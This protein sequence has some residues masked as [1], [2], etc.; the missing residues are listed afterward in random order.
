MITQTIQNNLRK[1]Q[2]NPLNI[3]L[4]LMGF[5]DKIT[6]FKKNTSIIVNDTNAVQYVIL[7]RKEPFGHRIW[8]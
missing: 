4:N 1:Q 8:Q 3:A 6:G 2:L 7:Y 5:S